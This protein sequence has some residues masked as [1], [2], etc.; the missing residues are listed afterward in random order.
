MGVRER[1]AK[2]PAAS[3]CAVILLALAAASCALQPATVDLPA[4]EVDRTLTLYSFIEEGELVTFIVNVRATRE[5]EQADYIPVEI[6]VGNRSVDQ[7]SLTRES[8]TLVDE[9]GNRYPCVGPKDLLAGYDFLDFD[10]KLGELASIVGNKFA[11]FERYPSSFSPVLNAPTATTSFSV[12]RDATTLPRFGYLID[13]IYFP[14]PPGPLAGRK[15]E[16]FLEAPELK[17]P[18]FVKFLV[19]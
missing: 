10:R 2:M 17:D 4:P 3:R 18:I 8:F 9:E 7:L 6:A 11:N 16:L 15:L 13:F 1:E 14:R 19:R 5:R 12:V